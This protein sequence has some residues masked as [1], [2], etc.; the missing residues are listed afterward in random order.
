LLSAHAK[1][2]GVRRLYCLTPAN[3]IRMLKL[4]ARLQMTLRRSSADD[5]II[6]AWRTL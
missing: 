4:A 6:E 5:A 2:H 1:A 3:N